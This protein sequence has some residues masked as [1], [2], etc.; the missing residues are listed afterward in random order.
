VT[1]DPME[2]TYT[3][4]RMWMQAVAKAGTT[5]VHPVRVAMYGQKVMAPAAMRRRCALI[6]TSPSR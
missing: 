2:A 3:G 5:V 6:I 1:N 4:F